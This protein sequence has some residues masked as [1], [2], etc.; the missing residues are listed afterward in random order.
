MM[1]F[2]RFKIRLS[3]VLFILP[4]PGPS[5]ADLSGQ[6]DSRVDSTTV[7]DTSRSVPS[8]LRADH[9]RVSLGIGVDRGWMGLDL[10]L[11][12]LSA[13]ELRLGPH[14]SIQPSLS[15]LPLL[16]HAHIGATLP[17]DRVRLQI[18]LGPIFIDRPTA[19]LHGSREWSQLIFG[20]SLT[21]TWLPF[22][23]RILG[24]F[25]AGSLMTDIPDN[26]DLLWNAG[27]GVSFGFHR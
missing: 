27:A 7:V 3:I 21:A 5:P 26:G 24:L 12:L 8:V 6:E 2:E 11:W 15:D 17:V 22:D 9:I 19:E 1:I 16:V 4:F 25:I 13:G 14:V 20:S 18:S 23:S 10:G